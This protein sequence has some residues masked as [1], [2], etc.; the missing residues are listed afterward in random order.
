MTP[1][2]VGKD[3][4]VV[5]LKDSGRTNVINTVFTIVIGV[6][7]YGLNGRQARSRADAP[8]WLPDRV[9]IEKENGPTA[10]VLEKLKAM[11]HNITPAGAG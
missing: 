7:E 2:M 3:G 1:S 8:Q 4:K 5:L 6:V 10:E 9:S 11:G